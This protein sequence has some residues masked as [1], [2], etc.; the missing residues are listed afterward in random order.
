MMHMVHGF[1]VGTFVVHCVAFS[2]LGVKR[3]KPYYFCLTGTFTFLTAVF[4]LKFNALTPNVSGTNFP[5]QWLFRIFAISCTLGY[6]IWISR[7]KG[8][9]LSRLLGRG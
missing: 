4:L 6:L 2:V 8:T 3:Q 1:L 9:W 7:I 5:L